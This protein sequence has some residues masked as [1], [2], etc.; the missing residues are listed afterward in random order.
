MTGDPFI[1]ETMRRRVLAELDRIEREEDVRI[2]LAVESG[3]R[4][5]RFPSQDSDYDVRFIY[6]R[7]VEEYLSVRPKRDVIEQPLDSL[8]DVSG[9]DLRKAF[10]LAASTNGTLLEWLSSPVR[11]RGDNPDCAMLRE[12]T[13]TT[14]LSDLSGHYFHMASRTFAEIAVSDDEVR[15]KKYCYAVRTAMAYLWLRQ[16]E[17]VPPMDLPSLLAGVSL[18]ADTENAISELV[19]RK[20]K[21]T[22]SDT[23]PRNATLDGLIAK[24][25][26]KNRNRFRPTDRTQVQ[27]Q[28]D[29]LFT[30][31]VLNAF[32]ARTR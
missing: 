17:E 5:W 13:R 11:Y 9:W 8:L 24:A 1:D 30:S 22:E 32:Q 25:L 15:L 12:F 18:P 2:L 31:I 19:T 27:A 28:A 3:S 21:S 26:G 20:A 29:A 7:P 16:R 14:D 10:A 23:I 6:V 4:A